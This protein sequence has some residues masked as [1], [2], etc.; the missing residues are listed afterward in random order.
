MTSPNRNDQ[1]KFRKSC[2]RYN[3]PG[4]AHSLTFSCYRRQPF[5]STAMSCQWFIDALSAAR[6][7]YEFDLWA[8]VLMPEHVHLLIY[9]RKEKYSISNILRSLKWPVSMQARKY[10]FENQSIV[11]APMWHRLSEG[12]A[13]TRF[14]QR[15]GGYDRNLHNS[16]LIYNT[17]EYIHRNPIRRGLTDLPENWN[18]S[19]AAYYLRGWDVPIVPD[20]ESLPNKSW[21]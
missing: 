21:F 13:A 3:I 6:E 16:R 4:H 14:W 11:L 10:A 2:R 9:P 5:F 7:K 17:I 15:G 1:E 18:W 19:S 20:L 12:R 8:Y